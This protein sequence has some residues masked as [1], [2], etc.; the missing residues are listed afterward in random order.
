MTG[1]TSA[2][3]SPSITTCS[4][5]PSDMDLNVL[6]L[7]EQYPW[8]DI[9]QAKN[10][11]RSKTDFSC[12]T[13]TNAINTDGIYEF[14]TQPR[15]CTYSE[16]VT[17]VAQLQADLAQTFANVDDQVSPTGGS[18][19][20]TDLRVNM[21]SVLQS[22]FLDPINEIIDGINCDYVSVAFNSFVDAMCTATVPGIV[23]IGAS[24]V[25]LALV[26]WL[27]ILL[28]FYIW[29]R[30]KDNESKWIE[31]TETRRTN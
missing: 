24:W 22:T 17:Y 21:R 27:V 14:T 10:S 7:S 15:L 9:V 26:G 4:G 23:A 13:Y 12:P 1:Y 30:L 25:A 11:V 28:E 2:G 6:S 19:V 3:L 16:Y 31:L 8:A 18:S 29:R 20:V 5:S